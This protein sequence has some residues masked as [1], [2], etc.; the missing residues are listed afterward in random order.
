MKVTQQWTTNEV[1]SCSRDF[2]DTITIDTITKNL[3]QPKAFAST[4]CT[5][6]KLWKDKKTGL[7]IEL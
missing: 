5:Y 4:L 7:K 2:T 3:Q 1:N 6:G